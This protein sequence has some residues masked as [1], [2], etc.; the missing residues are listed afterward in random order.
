MHD[1]DD[2]CRYQLAVRS[3]N[4]YTNCQTQDCIKHSKGLRFCLKLNLCNEKACNGED[5][6]LMFLVAS[7]T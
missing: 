7:S 5:A 1:M 2:W 3:S 6:N 4:A